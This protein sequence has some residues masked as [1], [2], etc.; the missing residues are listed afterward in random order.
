[1]M[2]PL[3]HPEQIAGVAINLQASA[4]GFFFHW[5]KGTWDLGS[6]LTTRYPQKKHGAR[7]SIFDNWIFHENQPF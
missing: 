2:V 5:L 4:R 1:L 3:T 7:V 6:F